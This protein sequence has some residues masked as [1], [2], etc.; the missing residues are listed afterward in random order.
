MPRSKAWA[1]HIVRYS[2]SIFCGINATYFAVSIVSR[3]VSVSCEAFENC[4]PGL[5]DRLLRAT[6]ALP[7]DVIELL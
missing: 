7:G 2:T 4:P 6:S 5:P 1:A 3:L